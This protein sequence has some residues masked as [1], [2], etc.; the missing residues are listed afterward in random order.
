ME[1]HMVKKRVRKATKKVAPPKTDS[2]KI[3]YFCKEPL[4]IGP[5][6]YVYPLPDRFKATNSQG[7]LACVVCGTALE[8]ELVKEGK[9]QMK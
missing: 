7:G 2:S 9:M 8:E 6:I 4:G 5:A 3:C 1:E